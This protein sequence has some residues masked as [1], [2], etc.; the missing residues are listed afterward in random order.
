MKQQERRPLRD[1]QQLHGYENPIGNS[2]LVTKFATCNSAVNACRHR[3]YILQQDTWLVGYIARSIAYIFRNLNKR[4]SEFAKKNLL[5]F[6]AVS[7]PVDSSQRPSK[8]PP[9]SALSRMRAKLITNSTSQINR[10][11]PSRG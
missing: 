5:E 3:F 7:L 10:V 8:N 9:I 2:K 1:T 4:I 11:L 6:K